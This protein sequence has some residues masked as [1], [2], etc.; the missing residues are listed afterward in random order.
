MF[1]N[2][3]QQIM[4]RNKNNWQSAIVGKALTVIL[5]EK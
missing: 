2:K 1:F 4:L 3:I 5:G